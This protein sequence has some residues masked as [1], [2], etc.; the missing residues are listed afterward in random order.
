MLELEAVK[1]GFV[2]VDKVAFGQVFLQ[3]VGFPLSGFVVD[4]VTGTGSSPSTSV[5]TCEYLSIKAPCCF[6]H[7]PRH[8]QGPAETAVQFHTHK[9]SRPQDFE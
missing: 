6:L 5:L 9:M 3:V 7:H 4:K 2:F 8:G 1:V